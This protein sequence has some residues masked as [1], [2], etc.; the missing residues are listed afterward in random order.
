MRTYHMHYS[1]V[2]ARHTCTVYLN[3]NYVSIT[4]DDHTHLI[5]GLCRSLH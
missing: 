3:Y 5:S 4:D 1:E 2:T